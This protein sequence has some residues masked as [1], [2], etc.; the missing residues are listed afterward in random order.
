MST[1]CLGMSLGLPHLRMASWG[2][3]IAPN[4]IVAVEGKLLLSAVTPDS[5]VL[6][7]TARCSLSGAPSRCLVRAD[8]R[9]R[10]RL[11]T[12]DSPDFTLDSPDFTP[13]SPVVFPPSATW[14]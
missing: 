7:R 5:P 10:C 12:P 13:D 2:V 14:N 8:D 1:I 9:W 3:F 11:F 6:H 4:T